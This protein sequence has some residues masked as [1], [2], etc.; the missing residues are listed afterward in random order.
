MDALSNLRAN[1]LAY[2][3][4]QH[5]D[6]EFL[7]LTTVIR[8]WEQ[9]GVDCAAWHTGYADLTTRYG[10]LGLTQFLPPDRFLVAVS[11]TRQQAFG[12]FHHPNQGYRHLQM[13]ALVTAYG[14]MNAEPS[15]LAVLDLLRGYAHDCLHYGSARRYQWRDGEVV[16]TQYG[17]NY[18]SAE[19]RSYSAR[20]KEGAESTRNL[21][22]VMEG[23]CDRE[24][25]SITRAAADTHAITEPAG[26]DRYAYRDVTGSLTEGDVAALAAGVPGE[27]PEHTLY[28]SSMGRYQATVNGRYGRFLDRIGGPEASGLHSTI[29]AAMISGDMRG[30]C[31]WLDGR[32]G[33]GA[34]AALFMTPSYLA[35]AS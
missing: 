6:H 33:P 5:P 21:G 2:A 35:L 32:F 25:R 10:D 17:I 16:R 15:E 24:A 19:G 31:A 34:F 22:V 23:A 9:Q 14:D 27:G 1:P 20:D 4:E 7:P 30:L 13:V 26:L 28:L 12:G 18:R 8:T 29:L 3:A 11:S